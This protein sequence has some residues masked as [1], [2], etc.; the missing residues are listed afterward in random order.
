MGIGLYATCAVCEIRPDSVTRQLLGYWSIIA[1][2]L[3]I[4]ALIPTLTLWLP[5]IVGAS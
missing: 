3:V 2:G 5:G 4:L 1:L